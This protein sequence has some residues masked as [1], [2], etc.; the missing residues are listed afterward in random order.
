MF[1]LVCITFILISKF[2]IMDYSGK[3]LKTFLERLLKYDKYEPPY[4]YFD[5]TNKIANKLIE[6]V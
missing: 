1:Y 6:Q 4:Q 2:L 3:S 5:I